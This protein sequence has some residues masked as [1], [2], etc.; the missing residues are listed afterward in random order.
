ML[1]SPTPANDRTLA[2]VQ[3]PITPALY[4][5]LRRQAAGLARIEVAR[6][7]YT[8]KTHSRFGRGARP[9]RIFASIADALS[10]I[11]QLELPGARARYRPVIDLLAGVFPLDPDVY[12]Q[13]A[14]EPAD[15]HPTLCR[16]CGCSKNDAC[17]RACTLKD[18]VC[19]HCASSQRRLAA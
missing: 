1:A 3:Q 10:V 18:D 4:L 17:D 11:E 2:D 16:E 9:R 19:S 14:E 12:H 8:F 7:L 15:R 5:R 13:L 6:R